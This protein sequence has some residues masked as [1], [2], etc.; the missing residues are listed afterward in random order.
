VR[1]R[2]RRASPRPEA[3]R[4]VTEPDGGTRDVVA[5]PALT[6]LRSRPDMLQPQEAP[7]RICKRAALNP[8]SVNPW[9]ICAS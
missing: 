5:G 6:C 8:N 9:L 3:R 2:S 1:K 7:K 4:L